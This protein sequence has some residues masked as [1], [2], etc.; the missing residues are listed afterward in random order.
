MSFAANLATLI[1]ADAYRMRAL[2]AVKSLG[3]PDCWVAAGF[4]RDAVWDRLHGYEPAEPRGD[5]DVVWF[6]PENLAIDHDIALEE[7]LN[8]E[9]PG[10]TWS[11]KNQARMHLRNGDQPYACVAD[12]MIHWPET[13]TAVAARLNHLHR[14]EICA[15]MGLEDLFLLQLVPTA[16]FAVRKRAVFDDRIASKRWLERYPLL[17]LPSAVLLR[18]ERGI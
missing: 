5:I 15:P 6:D 8:S 18:M 17:R 2:R 4:V 16:D 10:P 12:A 9:C 1:R 13:A 14:I 11:V 3:L 7:R